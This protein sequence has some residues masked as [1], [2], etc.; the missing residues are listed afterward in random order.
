MNKYALAAAGLGISAALLYYLSEEMPQGLSQ[1][2]KKD[3]TIQILK[4]LLERSQEIF[5]KIAYT[6]DKI[7]ENFIK[8]PTPN[9]L[10]DIIFSDYSFANDIKNLEE[11]IY[12]K[13]L[14]TEK[15]FQK[16]LKV[17]YASDTDVMVLAEKMQ[18]M[19]DSACRGVAINENSLIPY[20]L[21]STYGIQV[22]ADCYVCDLYLAY[23]KI[24]LIKEYDYEE[25][26]WELSDILMTEENSSKKKIFAKHGFKIEPDNSN[27]IIRQIII[28]FRK[29]STTFKESLTD[30]ERKYNKKIAL[31]LSKTFPDKDLQKLKEKYTDL[32]S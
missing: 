24:E 30:I 8:T 23:K 27:Y 18:H 7:K 6:A 13:N 14:V 11:E 5:N 3:Q 2:L 29:I 26:E 1:S 32:I 19:L 17:D 21:T 20:E 22:I 15:D 16:A 12:S 10:K 31:I 28:N 9:Q 4:E 25:D